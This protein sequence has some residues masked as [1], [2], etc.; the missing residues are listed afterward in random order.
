MPDFSKLEYSEL[1]DTITLCITVAGIILG[2]IY[3]QILHSLPT[4][5]RF[6]SVLQKSKVRN[7]YQAGVLWFLAFLQRVYGRKESLKAFNISL[8]LAYLYPF[9]FFLFSYSYLDG[10]N[11]FSSI[12]LFPED[13]P[14]RIWVFLGFLF[15]C[16]ISSAVI[17]R[18]SALDKY[19][20]QYFTIWLLW[21][22]LMNLLAALAL[23]YVYKSSWAGLL[24]FVIGLW[25]GASTVVVALNI[26]VVGEFTSTT[27]NA[28]TSALILIGVF[29]LLVIAIGFRRMTVNSISTL[30][31]N[32]AFASASL[33]VI[34]LSWSGRYTYSL[35]LAF[36]YIFLPLINT[37]LDW[38]SWWV[39]R[40]FMERTAVEQVSVRV[41]VLDVV[42]DFVVA[43]LFMLAL[44]LLLP[45]GAMGLDALYAQTVDANT[46]L[47]PQTNWQE[48]AVW[49][50][51]EPWGKGIMVTLMLV[52]TLIPTLLHIFL[53][54]VAFYIHA[55]K[56]QALAAFLIQA[57]PED[58]IA[59]MQASLWVFGYTILAGL[60]MWLLWLGLNQ[61]FHLPIAQWL[62]AFAKFFYPLPN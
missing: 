13:S 56:G 6:I 12:N 1:L 21:R 48:Y 44:V 42:L 22:G 38:L 49:A 37:L 29:P 60:S 26:A 30:A 35:L 55:F 39:S 3:S 8:I 51:D 5:Q 17:H 4:R 61:L 7:L 10:T 23:S 43:V 15:L 20:E 62:Y 53:G 18:V 59:N 58:N 52:T 54:L 11:K 47:A 19:W 46:G 50:R 34:Y 25:G 57:N 14:F 40:F 24:G 2:L 32:S 16:L 9:L 45:A 28:G 41:I 27:T 31:G 36:F 33:L